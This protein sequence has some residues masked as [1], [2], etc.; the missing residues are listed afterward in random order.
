VKEALK[1]IVGLLQKDIIASIPGP[2]AESA[3]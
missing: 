2:Q 3:L 1:D